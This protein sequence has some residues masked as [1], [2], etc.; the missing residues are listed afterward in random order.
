L[1]GAEILA[2]AHR[3]PPI[4]LGRII[5]AAIA[6]KATPQFGI[7]ETRLSFVKNERSTPV[8]AGKGE[9]PVF[10]FVDEEILPAAF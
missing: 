10:V 7:P 2:Q 4:R 5:S 8:V 3:R 1:G 6:A 9:A